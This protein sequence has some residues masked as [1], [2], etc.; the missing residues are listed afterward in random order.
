MTAA[1]T[2]TEPVQ[3]EHGDRCPCSVCATIRS[4]LVLG[5]HD[6]WAA[7]VHVAH[8]HGLVDDLDFELAF[9]AGIDVLHFG[10]FR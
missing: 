3:L 7:A 8:E 2:T 9:A 1:I 5:G 4:L 10:G 6:R